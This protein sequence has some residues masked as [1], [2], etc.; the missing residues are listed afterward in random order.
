ML[1][2]S[3]LRITHVQA[4]T[5]GYTTNW[6]VHFESRGETP[7]PGA[8]PNVDLRPTAAWWNSLGSEGQERVRTRLGLPGF[9][10]G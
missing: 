4:K 3:G 6:R 2:N 1:K 8:K 9:N 7:P 5:V 10:I